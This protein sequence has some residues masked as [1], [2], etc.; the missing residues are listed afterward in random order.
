[1]ADFMNKSVVIFGASKGI[2]E[3][4]A[5]YF[6]AR[7]A[8]VVLFARNQSALEQ[9]VADM[10]SKGMSAVA[11]A[12]DVARF[13]DVQRAVMIARDT[14]G[15]VDIVVNNAGLIDPISRLAQSDVE[16]W[17]RIVDINFKGVYHGLRAAIP[18][19]LGHGGTIINMSSGAAT[20]ALEG[21]SHYCSTKAAVLS[22]TQCAHKE[23]AEHGIHVIGLSP[24]TV[25]TDMQVAIRDSGVNP[26]S[27]LP[28]S[29]HIPVEWVAQSIAYLC[30]EEGKQF[31][32]R[33]FSL[34][35]DEGRALVGLPCITP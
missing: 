34:K 20:S 25:A 12:G 18:L 30:A 24:G 35:N 29:S 27:Q 5:R 17:G 13:E 22:L 28:W 10:K 4:S 31:A 8:K 32:G 2:G 14:F 15:Q 23:Y 21:W 16:A 9:I 11:C 33:D 3:A 19:M 1:M 7:G 26:V 6:G